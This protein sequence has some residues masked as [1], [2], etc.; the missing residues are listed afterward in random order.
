MQCD[1]MRQGLVL[2]WYGVGVCISSSL[3]L[4]KLVRNRVWVSECEEFVTRVWF[5]IECD[6][7]GY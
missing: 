6:T 3:E 7:V 2:L 5:L 4:L 1:A